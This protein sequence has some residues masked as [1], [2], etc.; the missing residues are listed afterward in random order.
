MFPW[1]DESGAVAGLYGRKILDNLRTGMAYHLY[2]PGPH[3][4]VFNA[5]GLV[6]SKEVIVC[7]AII[8]ALTFWCAGFT[9][10]TT[11]YGAEGFTDDHVSLFKTLGIARVI[12]AYDRD[13]TGDAAA[14]S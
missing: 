4:G 1:F 12:I 14:E 7:E 10:V 3:R 8:D 2:L 11:S 13:K 5:A 6:G 9:N